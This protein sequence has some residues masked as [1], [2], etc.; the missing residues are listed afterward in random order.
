M[1]ER[2]VLIMYG[3]SGV[4]RV[5]DVAPMKGSRGAEKN[6]L[7]YKLSPVYGSGTIYVPVDTKIFMRPVLSRREAMDLIRRI[8]EISDD[9]GED[10]SDWHALSAIYQEQLHSHDCTDLVHLIK[11]VYLK[12]RTNAENGRRPY[13]VDQEYQK[14]AEELL[15]SELAAALDI[16]MA[17]SYTHLASKRRQPL[18]PPG[19]RRPFP[20]ASRLA[21]GN[22]LRFPGGKRGWR[23]LDARCV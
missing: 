12:N 14:R 16:P 15:H 8:P 10:V 5:E 19:N 9:C 6:R 4:C 20:P 2:G 18:F 11:S 3:N 23:R 13:K 22:G 1:Y 21:G 7:Y 17:V